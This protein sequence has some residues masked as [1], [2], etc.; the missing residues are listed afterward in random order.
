VPVTIVG[1]TP[2]EF[3]GLEAGRTF[4]LALP[5]GAEPVLR[6]KGDPLFQSRNFS[7]LVMLRLAEGQT[8]D[9]ATRTLRDAQSAIVPANAP[10]FV[11]E[12]FVLVPA[13]RGAANPGAAQRIYER[14]LTVMLAGVALVLVIAGVN[15][16]NLLLARAAARR[17]DLGL[18]VALG[19][20]SWRMAR[21]VLV[22]SALLGAAGALCGAL[23]ALWA[24]RALVT[25]TPISLDPSLDWRVAIFISA[26]TIAAMLLAGLAPALRATRVPA[27]VAVRTAGRDLAAQGP[28]RL[29]NLLAIVQI[30]LALV[31]MI[32]GGLL[33][34]T[35][36]A[37]TQQPLGFDAD[38]VLVATVDTVRAEP[39]PA[40]R[41][42]LYRRLI[43]A[44]TAAPGVE[45][46]AAS[47]WTPLSGEG[48][49]IG[50]GGERDKVSVL[51]NF[52]TPGWFATYGMAVRQ[53]R[54]F[55]AADSA[56]APPV[57]VV[58]EAF[59]RRLFPTG[60]AIGSIALNGQTIVGVVGDAVSRSAQRIPGVS[61]LA[62]RE[63]VPPTIYVPLAQAGRWDRP[64]STVVRVSIRPRAGAPAAL[65]PAASAALAGVDPNVAFTFRPL[66]DDVRSSLSQER[67]TAWLAAAFG[68]LS[69]LLAVV[70]LY[71]LLS[72]RMSLRRSE[73]GVRMALGATP[74]EVQRLVIGSAL[75]L[76]GSGTV[77]GLAGAAL[78]TRALSS[79]LFGVTALDP[80]TFVGMAVALALI[81]TLAAL[82][83]AYRA[84]RVDPARALRGV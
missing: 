74:A 34:R 16:A 55:S 22:E 24:S 81:G 70:G 53:G 39:D 44:V 32:A 28:G 41:L 84:S 80:V 25:L 49:V 73:I 38:R 23:L 17:S 37:L 27:A 11:K 31:L 26:I 8:I 67:T 4:D 15:I 63:P 47:L 71:G 65:A 61:S 79:Q 30:T 18:R 60:N 14:P 50:A 58:N 12:P 76:I 42:D 13:A 9:S 7:L 64:P 83:P 59:V 3:R 33:V 52:V 6:G 66:T 77:A 72:Y 5:L 48:I 40:R 2:P 57:I 68:S 36:S 62:L 69:V 20:S 21:L 35:F 78:L 56:T 10:A 54:D 46:A 19:A 51:A 43:D 75:R 1:V 29:A 45:H 82:V